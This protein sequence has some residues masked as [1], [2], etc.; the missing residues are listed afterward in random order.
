MKLG[1]NIISLI[2]EFMFF[3]IRKFCVIINLRS[4]DDLNYFYYDEFK[5]V[6]F[7]YIFRNRI[8]CF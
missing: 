3:S 2:V 7:N 4:E 8:N 6:D 5:W 1:F